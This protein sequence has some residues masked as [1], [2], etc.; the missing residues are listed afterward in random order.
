MVSERGVEPHKRKNMSAPREMLPGGRLL[1][2]GV[3][4]LPIEEHPQL[5]RSVYNAWSTLGAAGQAKALLKVYDAVQRGPAPFTFG[6]MCLIFQNTFGGVA[7]RPNKGTYACLFAEM[8]RRLPRLPRDDEEEARLLEEA[9][10]DCGLKT[11]SVYRD[12]MQSK[13]LDSMWTKDSLIAFLTRGPL[14]LIAEVANG[15]KRRPTQHRQ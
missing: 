1:T 15:P 8:L 6:F 11:F 10:Y 2:E 14:S 3:P 4:Q 5:P 13:G 9:Y 7:S 12:F